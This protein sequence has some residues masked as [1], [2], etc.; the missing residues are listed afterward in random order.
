MQA[1]GYPK[2]PY[3][4]ANKLWWVLLS[5]LLFADLYQAA[6][7][8]Y[9]T[10]LDGDM[11]SGILITWDVQKIFDDP[12]G[13]N[14]ISSGYGHANP[15]RY[16]CHWAFAR[17]FQKAPLLLQHF[18]DPIQSVYLA[19]A[20]VKMVIHVGLL[21]FLALFVRSRT[22]GTWQDLLVLAL[23]L[24]PLMQIGHYCQAIGII[25]QSITYTFFYALPTLGILILIW[26]IH[27]LLQTPPVSPTRRN[28]LLVFTFGLSIVLP[29]S[30]PLV[31]PCIL[32]GASVLSIRFIHR[33][34][35]LELVRR[36]KMNGPVYAL[37]LFLLATSAYSLWLGT[38]NLIESENIPSIME[39]YTR[40][41]TGLL[42]LFSK[43]P[44]IPILLG[45]VLLNMIILHVVR[46]AGVRALRSDMAWL[47]LFVS[48]YVALL[49]WGGYRPWRENMIRFDTMIPFT[50][51]LFYFYLATTW[52]V[53]GTIT[54]RKWA[55]GLFIG[56]VLV[57]FTV[58]D[59]NASFSNAYEVRMIQRIARSPENIVALPGS[60]KLLSWTVITDP[61]WSTLQ[62]ELLHQWRILDRPKRFYFLED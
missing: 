55:Y 39:R 41:P 12:L 27:R 51:V 48:L 60:S 57:H 30:G 23:L 45:V 29:L 46:S 50:M 19:C 22:A 5:L 10:P 24:T 40:T 44:A 13:F 4:S 32:L 49:P 53:I 61:G 54:T 17:Y 6:T 8:Y 26:C 47:L 37:L 28:M 2:P 43:T 20:L 1:I 7:Q 15:N 3:V 59:F 33:Q 56:G 9:T 62:G 25:D 52:H 11:P 42:E 14:V 36:A 16:F 18:V 34:G 31:A 58:T 35:L 21:F 38:Y